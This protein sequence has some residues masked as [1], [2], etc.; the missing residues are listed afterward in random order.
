MSFL[1]LLGE[2]FGRFFVVG[3]FS[4]GGG[5]ATLPFLQSMGET[6][7]WFT[8]FDISNMVAISESTPGP[9]G[10]NMATYVGYQVAG[11][12]GSILAP[13]GLITP[14]IIVIIIISKILIKFRDSKY[15]DSAFYGLRAASVGLIA[16]ACF[17]VIKIAMFKSDVFAQTGSFFQAVDYKSV[18]LCA[19]IF[20]CVKLFKKVHPIVFIAAAAVIGIIFHMG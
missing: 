8:A 10:V 6:T 2:L 1:L 7:G 18:I 9:L 4:V 17:A 20:V 15:V 16:A 13:L 14:S 11:I 5:L 19:V 12:A 3:L